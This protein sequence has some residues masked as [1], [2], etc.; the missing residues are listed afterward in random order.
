[1]SVPWRSSGRTGVADVA[2]SATFVADKIN[3]Q[4]SFLSVASAETAI[5]Q[6]A[7]DQTTQQNQLRKRKSGY[8]PNVYDVRVV[9]LQRQGKAGMHSGHMI[10]LYVT[11]VQSFLIKETS[12]RCAISATMMMIM[13]AR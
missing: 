8:A 3:P 12:A 2:S 11:N 4:S 9:E 6:S 1:M 7:W 5:I 13:R 10:F